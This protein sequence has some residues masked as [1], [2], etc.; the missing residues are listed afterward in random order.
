VLRKYYVNWQNEEFDCPHCKWHGPGSALVLGDYN[1]ECA[2]RLCP[3]CEECITVVLHPTFEEA[4]ANWDKVSEWDRKNIE[5]AEAFQA[6]FKQR[7]LRESS[8][9]PDIHEPGFTLSWDNVAKGSHG[10]TVIKHGEKVIFSEPALWEGY[11]RFVEVAEILRS[12]YGAAL[13]DLI[14]TKGSELYL[15]GDASD[16]DR[17][18]A[19]ARKRIFDGSGKEEA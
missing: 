14:P 16:S 1:Y 3:V 2:E 10:E 9:L 8:Q 15:Y 11:K 5:A 17:V 19:A 6:E 7:K 18:V 4:R 12:R 13:R